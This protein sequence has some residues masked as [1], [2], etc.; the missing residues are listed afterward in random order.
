MLLFLW[1]IL[2]TVAV[3]FWARRCVRASRSASRADLV[4]PDMTTSRACGRV[5]VVV[6]AK[7]EEAV[8]ETSVTRLLAQDY[9]N[10]EVVVANDRST[11]RTAEI[12][13]RLEAGARGR[14]RVVHI[15]DLPAGWAGKTHAIHRAL[16][17]TSGEWLCFT[18][19]DCRLS[20]NAVSLAVDRACAARADFVTI[21]P[22]LDVAN[23]WDAVV[24]P[25]CVLVLLG[26]ARPH[27]AADPKSSAAYA[28]GAFMMIRRRCYD[29]LGGHASVRAELNEDLRLAQRAKAEGYRL[30]VLESRGVCRTQMYESVGRLL[31]GWGRQFYGCSNSAQQL[32]KTAVFLFVTG[33]MPL[34][35]FLLSVAGVRQASPATLG[36]WQTALVVWSVALLVQH[37]AVWRVYGRLGSRAGVPGFTFGVATTSAVLLNAWL[38][39]SGLGSVTWRGTRYA[40]RRAA[41]SNGLFTARR[42]R[43]SS[44]DFSRS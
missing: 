40:M 22:E 2:G 13:T 5:S 19:A 29:T 12:L 1:L 20:P 38:K 10:I 4:S 34:A 15:D 35:G 27:Q 17:F 6:A 26:W 11:D 9:H 21:V 30:R 16:P 43:S 32:L 41:D 24:Q 25:V 8:I 28:N 14:L 44:R 7:D 39:K 33:L 18:D 36:T 42:A 37:A 23:I 3:L 31:R